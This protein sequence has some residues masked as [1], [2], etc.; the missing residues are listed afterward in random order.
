MLN[1]IGDIEAQANI[2]VIHIVK[3]SIVNTHFHFPFLE[4]HDTHSLELTGSSSSLLP[5][6]VALFSSSTSPPSPFSSSV[7]APFRDSCSSSQSPCPVSRTWGSSCSSSSFR[8]TKLNASSSE[9]SLSSRMSVKS[10]VSTGSEAAEC[11][12]SA[13]I[14]APWGTSVK[15]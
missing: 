4:L 15:S 8:C 5:R 7:S 3:A 11:S 6:S 9:P 2:S 10:A 14:S 13:S 12:S 1:V